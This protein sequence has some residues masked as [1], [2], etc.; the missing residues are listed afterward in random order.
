MKARMNPD[1]VLL[2]ALAAAGAVIALLVWLHR[3]PGAQ[4]RV[5]V[6]N[7]ETA[8]FSLSEDTEYEI[9]S[10]YGVNRLEISGGRARLT[11]AD[12][13]DRLCVKQ[14]AVRYAGDSIICLPHR[15]VV[16][17]T[18]GGDDL[19]LDAVAK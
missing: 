1:R 6:D 16:E 18:G 15:V 11:D 3:E 7:E 4:V 2:L 14:G 19:E 13:P 5:L 17:I 10:P 9:R 8:V 12:C